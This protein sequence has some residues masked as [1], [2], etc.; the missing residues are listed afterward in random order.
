MKYYNY[1]AYASPYYNAPSYSDGVRRQNEA[2]FFEVPVPNNSQRLNFAEENC[3]G[4]RAYNPYDEYQQQEEHEWFPRA[5]VD[6]RRGVAENNRYGWFESEPNSYS[7]VDSNKRQV[8]GGP[9]S[10]KHVK[11]PSV[12]AAV[13]PSIP[14]KLDQRKH[15]QT[16]NIEKTPEVVK[17]I[18]K[19]P[20][21]PYSICNATIEDIDEE[22]EGLPDEESSNLILDPS[23][24]YILQMVDEI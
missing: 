1:P 21:S 15:V 5:P 23:Y 16:F 12:S 6:G 11:S 13:K 17:P 20:S 2:K 4:R 7:R 19:K 22:E 8:R 10:K 18:K 3:G 14:S 9:N 24:P